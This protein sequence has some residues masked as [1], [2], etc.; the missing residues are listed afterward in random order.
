MFGRSR[1]IRRELANDPLELLAA[2]A[3]AQADVVRLIRVLG[4]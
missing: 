2:D 3:S 4:R 1:N